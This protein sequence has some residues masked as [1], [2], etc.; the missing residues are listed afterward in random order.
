VLSFRKIVSNASIDNENHGSAISTAIARWNTTTSAMMAF[1]ATGFSNANGN[2]SW[3]KK[4]A[5]VAIA[6]MTPTSVSASL[7]SGNGRNSG[8]CSG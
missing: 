2:A 7:S 8:S 4:A 3:M 6:T 5:Y 1:R